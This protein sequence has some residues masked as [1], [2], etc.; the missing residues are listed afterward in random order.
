MTLTL[1]ISLSGCDS[2]NTIRPFGRSRKGMLA[3]EKA[4]IQSRYFR[5]SFLHPTLSNV[6]YCRI[7]LPRSFHHLAHH[8]FLLCL[9]HSSRWASSLVL[10]HD[11]LPLEFLLIKS[12]IQ[13]STRALSHSS[14]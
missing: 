4:A 2:V 13:V 9:P 11:V 1:R 6:Y 3:S 5:L 14:A 7:I 8:V 10:L 12:A